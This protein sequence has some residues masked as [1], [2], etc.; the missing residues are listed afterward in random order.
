MQTLLS[1]AAQVTYSRRPSADNANPEDE[2]GMA[3][4]SE[5]FF[6]VISKHKTQLLVAQAK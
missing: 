5:T 1:G 6:L 2:S 3:M 4:E